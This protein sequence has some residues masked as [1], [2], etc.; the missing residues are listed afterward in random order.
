MSVRE[1]IQWLGSHPSSLWL[2]LS[3]LPA[4]AL[5]LPLFHGKNRGNFAPWQYFYALITYLTCLPGMLACIVVAYSLFFS[6][7]N[8]LDANALVYFGP[9]IS[10]TITLMIMAKQVKFEDLPGFDRL[11]GLLL[12]MG[13]TFA[14]VLL[15]SKMFIGVVF[16]GSLVQL[17]AIATAVF[18]L[19]KWAAHAVFRGPGEARK[20]RPSLFS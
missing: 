15:I 14:I 13:G 18:L 19:L 10:M 5:V 4:L 12:L 17:L 6:R 16:A 8:L 11:S 1:V 9:P 3:L 20:P 2:F 7:D